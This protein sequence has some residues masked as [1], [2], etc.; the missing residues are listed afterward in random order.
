MRAT[1]LT[2][3]ALCAPVVLA[4]PHGGNYRHQ[5]AARHQVETDF[6]T[7]TDVVT[8]TANNAV[9]W[10][11]Q[12][13][14]ILS[15]EYR[16]HPTPTIVASPSSATP[17]V[18]PTEYASAPAPAPFSQVESASAA[19]ESPVAARIS[20]PGSAPAVSAAPTS[21]VS[22]SSPSASG[23]TQPLTTSDSASAQVS[24]A[25]ASGNSNKGTQGGSNAAA[26][27]YGICYELIGNNG[28]KDQTEM[29]SEF[30]FLA[31][32]GYS[33]I[34]FYDIGCDLGVATAAASANGLQV[35]LGLNTIGN[36]VGD[37]GTLVGMIKGN[38]G[39]VDTVVIGNEVVNSGGSAAAVVAALAVARPI[40]QAA[41]FTKSVVTVDTFT[42][43]QNNP[44]L[45][46]ASDF[47]AVNAHAFFDPNTPA[48]DAGTFVDGVIAPIQAKAN[49]K[50]V[51][52]TESGWP[53]QGSPNGQ[54]IPSPANQQT[55]IN[56]LMNAFSTNSSSLFL[57]QA[58]DA[59]YK[60]PGAFGV[61]QYFG[62][63]GH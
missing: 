43:H 37:L 22:N 62:I 1:I 32:Q 30:G 21:Q 56:S 38:W 63:Y 33:K 10:V 50:Q 54:A 55:A 58:Y 29:D 40:L 8:V 13:N 4:V 52:V 59:T 18:V 45:C 42:A 16:D 31:S 35:M 23:V 44:Q 20:G 49:G 34:R 6:A 51:I 26:G 2:L 60:A 11:D 47:C 36:V 9:V 12:Y 28:C 41:G 14:N 25:T 46:Q 7:V 17:V 15:T 24:S 5:H 53:Y 27:G 61:E 3:A 57:F 19:S 39:P 48:N